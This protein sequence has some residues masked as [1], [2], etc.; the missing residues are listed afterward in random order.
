MWLYIWVGVVE[1]IELNDGLNWLVT[2]S[3]IAFLFDI[4]CV[5]FGPNW[6]FTHFI[7]FKFFNHLLLIKNSV[8]LILI[9]HDFFNFLLLLVSLLH[10]YIKNKSLTINVNY[11]KTFSM[12]YYISELKF[13]WQGLYWFY[14][15]HYAQMLKEY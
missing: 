5:G 11:L 8:L 7:S 14:S 9:L 10:I 15:H 12:K 4:I 1:S 2:R 13:E 3:D 6:S